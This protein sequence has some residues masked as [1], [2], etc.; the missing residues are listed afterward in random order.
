[1]RASREI[2]RDMFISKA[3]GS[4]AG[5]TLGSWCARP[6]RADARSDMR[7]CKKSEEGDY[8]SIQIWMHDYK[9][10]TKEPRSPP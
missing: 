4:G 9:G 2:Y 6:S 3:Q 10:L 5:R 1:M 7:A 8:I